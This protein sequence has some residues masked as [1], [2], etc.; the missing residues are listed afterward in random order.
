M[1]GDLFNRIFISL[2]PFLLFKIFIF[3]IT[4]SNKLKI[5]QE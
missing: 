1:L 5:V 3:A 2:S 4:N